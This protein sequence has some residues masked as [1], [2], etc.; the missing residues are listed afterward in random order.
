MGAR[1]P[2]ALAALLGIVVFALLAARLDFVCD[3]AYITFRYA[4]NWADGHGLVYHVGTD[5]PVEG[6]SE[7]LWALLVGVGMK[8]GIAPE[9]ASRV[10]SYAAGAALVV[11][12]ARASARRFGPSAPATFGATLFAAS[13]PP[14][15]AWSSGGM[16]TMPAVTLGFGLFLAATR[17]VPEAVSIARAAAL[18]AVLASALALTRADGALQV[19]LVLGPLIVLGAASTERRRGAA[20]AL[21]AA[22]VSASAF[23]MHVLWRSATYGD[24]MPN[25]ARV[26]LG[27][28]ARATERGLDYVLW[29]LYSMPGIA[30]AVALGLV[31]LWLARRALGGPVAASCATA[32]AGTL[33]YAVATGGDFMC[34]ARFLAPAVPFAALGLAALLH[35]IPIAPAAGALGL[36]VSGTSAAASFDVDVLPRGL[37]ASHHFRHNQRLGGVTPTESEYEQWA[38]M[39]ERAADWGVLGRALRTHVPPGSS[40][41]HGAVGAIGYFS[42]LRIYDRNGL[43]T[44]EVALREPHEELRSPGHDKMVPSTFFL[45]DRPDYLGVGIAPGSA[46]DAVRARGWLVLG[47]TERPD[48]LLWGEPTP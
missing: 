35:R 37:R 34:F 25:T 18:P 24:W 7:F 8:L 46:A 14:I 9:I 11:L 1:G 45:K 2:F 10:V 26:K 15:S 17:R 13:A 36:L 29:N 19:A 30:L 43:V 20:V 5:A 27:F 41:V 21:A 12:V 39:R 32:L 16:A 6:Y 42:G 47:A 28:S 33:S 3:D 4:R 38:R 40:I 22:I 31:G 48:E 23:G 44:R